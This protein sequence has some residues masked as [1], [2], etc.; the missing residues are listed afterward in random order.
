MA[1]VLQFTTTTTGIE[2]LKKLAT[3]DPDSAVSA[4]AVQSL[5]V[6]R[7]HDPKAWFVAQL[8]GASAELRPL[9]IDALLAR[10]ARASLLLDAMEQ[11]KLPRSA[12]SAQHRAVLA[13]YP[14]ATVRERAAKLFAVDANRQALIDDYIRKTPALTGDTGRGK[15]LFTKVCASC[16]KVA[17]VG[18]EVG[19]N[20]AAFVQRGSEAV[21]AN[22]LD[23][24]REINPQYLNH[25]I[26]M[27]D[28]EIVS[29]VV[30]AQSGNSVTVG[31]AGGAVRTIAKSE[32]TEMRST[33]KSLMPDGLEAVVTPQAMAD[34]IAFLSQA[35]EVKP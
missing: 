19:P 5:S 4:A 2:L 35:K 22:V 31:F 25:V 14:D 16:H 6:M 34:L 20:L 23:P 17:G 30:L 13:A 9:L 1:R 3:T 12:C 24:S 33:G 27:K 21:I 28:G 11:D 18:H 29:G 15:E 7:A 8:P 10:P 26:S 32:I